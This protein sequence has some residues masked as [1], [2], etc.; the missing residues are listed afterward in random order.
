MELELKFLMGAVSAKFANYRYESNKVKWHHEPPFIRI[1]TELLDS[2]SDEFVKTIKNNN[3]GRKKKETKRKK[4]FPSNISFFLHREFHEPH[5]ESNSEICTHH[6]NCYVYYKKYNIRI[7]NGGKIIC[8]GLKHED[9]SDFLEYV[10]KISDYLAKKD[11]IPFL[12]YDLPH[13]FY[14]QLYRVFARRYELQELK[15][16]LENYQFC[17][18]RYIDL[19]KLQKYFSRSGDKLIS[20]DEGKFLSFICNKI[21]ERNFHID[22]EI[23][24]EL[25]TKRDEVICKFIIKD[26]FIYLLQNWDLRACEEKFIKMYGEFQEAYEYKNIFWDKFKVNMLRNFVEYEYNEYHDKLYIMDFSMV[27]SVIYKE[28]KNMLMLS[29]KKD[30]KTITIR[31]F[32][33][34]IIDILGSDN[35]GICEKIKNEM[36]RVFE[37]VNIFYDDD[38]PPILTLEDIIQFGADK[39][40]I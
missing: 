1:R 21:K 24:V 7:F 40:L 38:D 37:L 19:N 30:N 13:S 35:K 25:F 20:I 11:L 2:V 29:K 31:I 36:M 34:G 3:R 16:T 6:E 10:Q 18:N 17:L 4:V 9:K 32:G 22:P 28:E 27:E 39:M 14:I 8:V 26:A 12:Q 5:Q 33:T 23:I 15:S